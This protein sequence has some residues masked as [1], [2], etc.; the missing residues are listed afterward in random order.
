LIY[1]TREK[2]SLLH[3]SYSLIFAG[4]IGNLIDRFYL[5][6]VV[7]FLDFFWKHDHFPAF[8]IADSSISIAACLLIIDFLLHLKKTKALN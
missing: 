2:D 4:A 7:D 8:N 1:S 6:Y 3:V 5:G